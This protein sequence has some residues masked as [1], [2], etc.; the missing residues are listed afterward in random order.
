M[1]DTKT[2]YLFQAFRLAQALSL[3]LEFKGI[4]DLY[5]GV[6]PDSERYFSDFIGLFR[7]LHANIVTLGERIEDH[8]PSN[9]LLIL[10][11]PELKSYDHVALVD[12]D[13]LP[14]KP[15][16]AAVLDFDGVQ[17]KIADFNTLD[18]SQLSVV[19][20]LLGLP[21]PVPSWQTSLDRVAHTCYCN[22]GCIVFS[23]SILEEFVSRW[24]QFNDILRANKSVLGKRVYFLDQ[25][26][27]CACVSTFL[28]RFRPL[29]IG[30]NFPGHI[31][32]EH[33][34]AD[35][36]SVEPRWL[37]YH[38]KVDPRTGALDLTALPNVQ[39]PVRAFNEQSAPVLKALRETPLFWEVYYDTERP[40][41][42]ERNAETNALLRCVIDSLEPES[43]LDLGCGTFSPKGLKP[44]IAYHGID[45]SA[46][47]IK[48]AR[49]K[50]PEYSYSLGDIRD[51]KAPARADLIMILNVIGPPGSPRD[52][53]L[54]ARVL[55]WANRAVLVSASA[56]DY[57]TKEQAWKVFLGW[58]ES[59]S[60]G[61][62]EVGHVGAELF[63]LRTL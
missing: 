47:A 63:V 28:D 45:W 18:C 39:K 2:K 51:T 7:G 22:T 38:D 5:I 32:V 3:N 41:V 17:A 4:A 60:L 13:T 1:A 14:I 34:P 40:P 54:L 27:F 8:G 50:F 26:S 46:Q 29:P 31:S 24:R 62:R 52:E 15:F 23:R 44:F 33:Y 21:M 11:T 10:E 25:A 61:F 36:L 42:D 53:K 20:E 19:F 55:R 6:F 30:M 59:I 37:H 12:C 16:P 56:P 43:I 48:M 57:D 49:Q 9:K 35:T 58:L